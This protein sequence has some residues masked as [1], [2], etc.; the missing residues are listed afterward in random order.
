MDG[1]R[2]RLALVIVSPEL[3]VD[4]REVSDRLAGAVLDG[5]PVAPAAAFRDGV[6]AGRLAIDASIIGA[7]RRDARGGRVRVQGGYLARG[8]TPGE[9]GAGHEPF[10]VLTFGEI[11][12][13]EN[14]FSIRVAEAAAAVLVLQ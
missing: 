1:A 7:V 11:D 9:P 3:R 2:R 14:L 13:P 12:E 8:H 10:P 5:T 6:A 4:K